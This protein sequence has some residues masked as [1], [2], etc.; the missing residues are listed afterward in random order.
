MKEILDLYKFHEDKK[1]LTG[2]NHRDLIP[3]VVINDAYKLFLGSRGQNH[4]E[5]L[6]Y[7]MKNRDLLGQDANTAIQATTLYQY[8]KGDRGVSSPPLFSRASAAFKTIAN[9]PNLLIEYIIMVIRHLTPELNDQIL[10]ASPSQLSEYVMEFH[11]KF[12]ARHEQFLNQLFARIS[13]VPGEAFAIALAPFAHRRLPALEQALFKY[14][15]SPQDWGYVRRGSDVL[16]YPETPAVNNSRPSALYS[17]TFGEYD[18]P[19]NLYV[20]GLSKAADRRSAIAR[21]GFKG[22]EFDLGDD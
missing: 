14:Q 9:D 8:A 2:Y 16:G 19:W 4:N 13:E 12:A 18:S 11:D 1:S 10:K 6:N 7:L 5:V 21:Y 22:R 17:D 20:S 15:P 3:Q